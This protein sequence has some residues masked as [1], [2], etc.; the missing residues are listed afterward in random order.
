MTI[1]FALLRLGFSFSLLFGLALFFDIG[2]VISR[3]GQIHFGWVIFAVALSVP[4]FAVS[5]WRWR[6]TA[7][8]LGIDLPFSVALRE[9]YLSTFL[10]Q[11][12]PG[13]VVG[14]FSRAWRHARTQIITGSAIRA[15]ILERV[16]CQVVMMIVA[17]V[18][19]L[20]LPIVPIDWSWVVILLIGIVLGVIV[21]SLLIWIGSR[22]SLK[23][24]LTNRIWNDTRAALFSGIA[25]PVHL[26][27]A[28]FVVGSYI[29]TYLIAARSVGVDT[30]LL[31]MLPLVAPIL[32]TM[33]IPIT[34]SG[35]G[36][37]EGAAAALWAEMGL[38]PIEGVMVSVAYGLL[39]LF[40]SVVG[41]LILGLLR[42]VKPSDLSVSGD[43]D[44]REYP[45]QDGSND[46][47]DGSPS[48]ATGSV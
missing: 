35:W 31:I 26:G 37:R 4:Q 45:Y 32:L 41:G 28:M 19:F 29:T 11:V 12:L 13:G 5:A 10:N 22:R 9:Y 43:R 39:V 18:S 44:Q 33:L 23:D 7:K 47:V 36:M 6:F 16:S 14:D 42:W 48:Q 15:V 34:V 27:S 30:S 46:T 1:F 8:R 2:D 40:S 38:V 24:S 25:V 20:S 21:G 17:I 3:L